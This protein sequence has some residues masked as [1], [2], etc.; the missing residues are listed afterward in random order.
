[1][2]KNVIVVNDNDYVNGGAALVAIETANLL[3]E[4][5]YNVI[6]FCAVSD[7]D[8]SILNKN[9]KVVATNQGFY[10]NS[11][12]KLKGC[13]RG[14]YDRKTKK[15]FKKIISTLDSQETIVSI[16]GYTKALSPSFIGLCKKYK[17][18]TLFTVHDYFCICPNGGLFNYKKNRIC[19][20]QMS[21]KCFFCNCDSRNYAFKMYRNLRFFVQDKILRFRNKIDYAITICESNEKYIKDY[22]KKSKIVRIYNPTSIDTKLDRA[23]CENNKYYIYIGRVTKEK[24]LDYTCECFKKM[25]DEL[26]IIGDGEYLN[27][28]KEKYSCNNIKFLGWKN[29]CDV[30]NLL[31]KSKGLIFPSL[32]PEGAPLTVFEA[33]AQGIPCIVSKYSNG[34]DF[35]NNENGYIYDPYSEELK[36]I[37][38]NISNHQ[39]QNKSYKSYEDYWE[40]PYTKERYIESYERL[41]CS[42]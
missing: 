23:E 7:P 39:I 9:I 37:I 2:I 6:F 31:R 4:H 1:M 40:C 13:I 5:G 14:L 19:H 18:K 17:I 8:K 35:I 30:I 15:V 3:Y 21:C 24:G 20:K 33:M 26:Y 12:N 28:L 42:L 36:L 29:H 10:L 22:F 27:V 11:K 41:F 32:L 16:H 25:K 38:S 34:K